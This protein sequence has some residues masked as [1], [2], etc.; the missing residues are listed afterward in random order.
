MVGSSS[1]SWTLGGANCSGTA[2]AES[3]DGVKKRF[4]IISTG[5]IFCGWTPNKG[6]EVGR[7]RDA[8]AFSP[9]PSDSSCSEGIPLPPSSY[10]YAT[11][12]VDGSGTFDSTMRVGCEPILIVICGRSTTGC[13]A[14]E[15]NGNVSCDCPIT[16]GTA[17]A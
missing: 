3:A 8:L 5:K 2:T 7:F 17:T 6:S 13:D 9:P 4:A 16:N 11:N 15:A 10:R 14:E 12:V 1:A